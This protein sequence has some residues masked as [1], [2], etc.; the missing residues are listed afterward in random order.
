MPKAVTGIS[1]TVLGE[2]NYPEATVR[3]TVEQAGA[4]KLNPMDD[5]LKKAKKLNPELGWDGL[6][7]AIVREGV[8]VV[9]KQ[10]N[11]GKLS[12]FLTERRG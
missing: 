3:V 6:V 2:R 8:S 4:D 1:V 5:F 11:D 10:I 7:R 9:A 12:K